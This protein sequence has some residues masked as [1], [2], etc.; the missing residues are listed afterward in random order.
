LY[1][2]NNIQNNGTS[3]ISVPTIS[4]PS[5]QE[6]LVPA[7]QPSGGVLEAVVIDAS[8]ETALMDKIQQALSNLSK[9]GYLLEALGAVESVA[10]LSDLLFEPMAAQLLSNEAELIPFGESLTGASPGPP[11]P[12]PQLPILQ[13]GGQVSP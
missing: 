3:F 5:S 8:S 13:P 12:P 4:G 2:V 6:F 11:D 1:Q 10:A 7:Y 9:F